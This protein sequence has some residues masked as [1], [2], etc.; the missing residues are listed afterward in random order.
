MLKELKDKMEKNNVIERS[1]DVEGSSFQEEGWGNAFLVHEDT[2]SRLV[3]KLLTLI[4]TWGLNATQEAAIK[5]VVRHAV[6]DAF[7]D[8]WIIGENDHVALRKKAYE[9]GQL[10]IGGHRPSEMPR[11]SAYPSAP[12]QTDLIR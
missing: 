8:A 11:Y 6:Y 9:F 10:S 4:E 3:G 12:I 1:K 2:S 5:N 7:D